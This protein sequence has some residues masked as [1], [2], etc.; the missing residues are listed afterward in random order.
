[1][2]HGAAGNPFLKAGQDLMGCVYHHIHAQQVENR[3]VFG[4]LQD[5]HGPGNL[6]D[7][8]CNL[9]GNEVGLVSAG[10]NEQVGR[11]YSLAQELPPPVAAEAREVRQGV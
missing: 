6:E 11:L 7:V 1:V 3:L 9:T 8:L 5:G 2:K 4:V 10:T